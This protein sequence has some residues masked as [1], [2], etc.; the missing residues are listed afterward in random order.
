MAD[1]SSGSGNHLGDSNRKGESTKG[2]IPK[3]K[4]IPKD[5]NPMGKGIPKAKIPRVGSKWKDS[6]GKDRNG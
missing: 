5:K 3:E 4:A 6:K 1:P 2:K